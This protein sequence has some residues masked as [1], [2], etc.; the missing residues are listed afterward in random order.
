MR[1]NASL[2]EGVSRMERSSQT[3][4]ASFAMLVW[5]SWDGLLWSTLVLIWKVSV[6][7]FWMMDLVLQSVSETRSATHRQDFELARSVLLLE[8]GDCG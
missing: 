1:A 2:M 3:R 8:V 6:D 7:V 4:R 5:M